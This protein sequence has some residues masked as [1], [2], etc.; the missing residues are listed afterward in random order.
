MENVLS[1]PKL[2]AGIVKEHL[3]LKKIIA[4][5]KIDVVIS[6]NRF[7]LWNKK[8]PCVFITHDSIIKTPFAKKLVHAINKWFINK[9]D[10]CW[11]PDFEGEDNLSVIWHKYPLSKNAFF[12][13]SLSR[14][15][16]I[17]N[18]EPQQFKYDLLVILS[19]PRTTK[20]CF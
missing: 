20:N 19:G 4:E 2:I 1:I 3:T 12:I 7:G 10:E 5:K 11:I 17:S 14:F 8:I 9:Y 16:K 15:T 18:D 13:G 6:N